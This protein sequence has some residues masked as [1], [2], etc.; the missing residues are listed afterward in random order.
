MVNDNPVSW[1][2][3]LIIAVAI[4]VYLFKAWYNTKP[5]NYWKSHDNFGCVSSMKT[6]LDWGNTKKKR[7]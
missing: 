3:L 6:N 2:V 1:F 7:F 5:K 4:G